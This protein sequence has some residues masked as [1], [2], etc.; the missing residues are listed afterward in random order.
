MVKN[1]YLSGSF[2]VTG[3]INVLSCNLG[4]RSREVQ[5]NIKLNAYVG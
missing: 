5:M 1:K 4:H 3:K 2:H